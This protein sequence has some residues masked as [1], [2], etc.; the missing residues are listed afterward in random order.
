MA[1]FPGV[2]GKPRGTQLVSSGFSVYKKA[3]SPATL[4][5]A[6]DFAK[7]LTSTDMLVRLE[8][9]LYISARKSA[10]AQMYQSPEWLEFKP[11]IAL[12][13]HELSTY[14]A[15]FWG[16]QAFEPSWTR[17]KKFMQAAFEAIYSRSKTPEQAVKDFV[18]DAA[19]QA[20]F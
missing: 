5:A 10:N 11:D 14:G 19:P 7:H 13:E 2:P 15:P 1:P 16:S 18:R 6:V 12:Y 9:L 4:E 8:S 17:S 20:G 3:K